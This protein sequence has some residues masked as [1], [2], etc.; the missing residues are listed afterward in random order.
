MITENRIHSVTTARF[1]GRFNFNST[2]EITPAHFLNWCKSMRRTLL[3]NI[4]KWIFQ[5]PRNMK[6]QQ[7]RVELFYYFPNPTPPRKM[8]PNH[9]PFATEH[10]L[11]MITKWNLSPS[12]S[13]SLSLV[14]LIDLL[15]LSFSFS[16]VDSHPNIWQRCCCVVRIACESWAYQTSQ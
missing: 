16:N 11:L 5:R 6:R 15:Q 12:V 13:L 8:I 10:R 14:S 7:Q 9:F 4:R 2:P 3:A 1:T